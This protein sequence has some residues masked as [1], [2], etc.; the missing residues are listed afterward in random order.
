MEDQVKSMAAI[1]IECNQVEQDVPKTNFR[2]D[3][4]PSNCCR[5][6]GQKE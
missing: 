4:A 6:K 5:A 1:E 2:V 3:E